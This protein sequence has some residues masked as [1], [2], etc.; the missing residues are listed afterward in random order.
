MLHSTASP[1]KFRCPSTPAKLT[2]SSPKEKQEKADAVFC[3][4]QFAP[5]H[6]NPYL[7]GC[8]LGFAI[9]PLS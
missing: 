3:D 9:R 1:R 8:E 4:G 2:S 6:S 5:G 7:S